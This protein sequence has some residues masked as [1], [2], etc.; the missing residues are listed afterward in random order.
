MRILITTV[1]SVCVAFAAWP[2]LAAANIPLEA[3]SVVL[4]VNRAAK[5]NDLA[6]LQK[7][8]VKEFTWSFGGDLDA[9]QALAAWKENPEAIK[10][11]YRVT[12]KQCTMREERIVECP[13]NAGINYR[14]GFQNTE[15]G[16]RMIY[17]VAGD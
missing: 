14:A 6:A 13:T 8:M 15:S 2:A 16:W 11:L 12:S 17:F 7:L 5:A 9:E 1:V 3:Q 10:E 4:K